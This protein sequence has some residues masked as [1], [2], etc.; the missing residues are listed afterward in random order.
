MCLHNDTSNT[1]G[2]SSDSSS[3]SDVV[4]VLDGKVPVVFGVEQVKEFGCI[5]LHHHFGLV[6]LT[7]LHRVDHLMSGA[8]RHRRVPKNNVNIVSIIDN[9]QQNKKNANQQNSRLDLQLGIALVSIC[10]HVSMLLVIIS[11]HGHFNSIDLIIVLVV[12][13]T[14]RR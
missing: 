7:G 6:G 8:E 2:F 12:L 3:E 13:S 9:K 11:L 14:L 1:L 10:T 5:G 4:G